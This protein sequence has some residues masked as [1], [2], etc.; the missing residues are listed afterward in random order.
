MNLELGASPGDP[1]G[2]F[3][4]HQGRLGWP[5]RWV[6]T[7]ETFPNTSQAISGDLDWSR[8]GCQSWRPSQTPPSLSAET[9]MAPEV[10]ASPGDPP[11]PLGQTWM[12]VE[13]G[14][15]PRG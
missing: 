3:P 2:P 11:R 4:G 10:G 6:P 13:V 7:L 14:A 12:A 9:W 8:G 5:S 1:P 15:N